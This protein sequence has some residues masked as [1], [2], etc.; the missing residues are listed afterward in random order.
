MASASATAIS[1]ISSRTLAARPEIARPR[2]PPARAGSGATIGDE[3]KRSIGGI[4]VDWLDCGSSIEP[5]ERTGYRNRTHRA[6][7]E[8]HQNP[9]FDAASPPAVEI[10]S[11]FSFSFRRDDLT[12]YCC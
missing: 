7:T 9:P 1:T 12:I 10:A 4:T 2:A 6:L 8:K 11:W 5:L 3:G